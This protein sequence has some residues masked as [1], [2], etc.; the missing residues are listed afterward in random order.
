[1]QA[2]PVVTDEQHRA[3]GIAVTNSTATPTKPVAA[4]PVTIVYANERL[5]NET[6]FF[7]EAKPAGAMGCEIWIKIGEAPEDGNDLTFLSLDAA[8]PYL[9]EYSGEQTGKVACEIL[10]RV[11]TRSER[12][13]GAR[14]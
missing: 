1:M 7:D 8:S 3:M 2:L 6:R 5:R 4:H 14:R 11:T 12:P 9:A 10:R 13:P